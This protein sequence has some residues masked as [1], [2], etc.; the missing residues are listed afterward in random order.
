MAASRAGRAVR[1]GL[2]VVTVVAATLSLASVLWQLGGQAAHAAHGGIGVSPLGVT[3]DAGGVV[4][5]VL[6][7][8]LL[9][10]GYHLIRLRGSRFR[11][12]HIVLGISLGTV[13]LL[14]GAGAV[15]H[16]L[17]RIEPLPVALDAM[18][19]LLA[20][21]VAVQVASGY[22]QAGRKPL[23]RAH[24]WLA[25]FV[26]AAVVTHSLLGVYHTLTG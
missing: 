6:L 22:G 5:I 10:S 23:R 9:M 1:C 7:G 25:L 15:V 12:V 24:V 2:V 19:V 16:T 13:A 26:G 17:A 18:G 20:A 14:H 3:V 11:G 4:A 21:A 8:L